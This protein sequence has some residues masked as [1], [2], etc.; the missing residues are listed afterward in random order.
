M[1]LSQIKREKQLN[2]RLEIDHSHVQALARS[3]NSKLGM[4]DKIWL[5]KGTG[6]LIAGEYRLRALQLLKR[7]EIPNSD[8]EYKDVTDAES[9][10]NSVNSAILEQTIKRN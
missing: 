5:Q 4:I 3:I 9:A 1:K 7:S 8:I 10:T 2:P 6:E